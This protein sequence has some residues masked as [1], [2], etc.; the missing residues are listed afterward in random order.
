MDFQMPQPGPEHEKLAQMAGEWV[1]EETLAPSP[2]SPE[3]Q[4]RHGHLSARVL[5]RFFVVSD[6]EQKDAEG[7][8]TFRGHGVYSWDAKEEVY[9]MHW[10]DSMG[11]AGSLAKGRIEGNVLTFENSSPMGRHRYQYTFGD[12]TQTFEMSMSPDGE[13]WQQLMIANYSAK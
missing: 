4:T 10:F 11:G 3:E 5:D 9:R 1:G 8:V 12:G 7:Q 6:Y 13:N 2:W